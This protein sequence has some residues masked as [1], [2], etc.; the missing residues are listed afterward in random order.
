MR[1]PVRSPAVSGRFY[2][3]DPAILQRDVDRMLLEALAEEPEPSSGGAPA[4]RVNVPMAAIVPHAGYVFSGGVAAHAYARLRG[5][6]FDTVVLTGPDHYVG[7]GGVALYPRGAFATPLGPVEIDEDL[8][9]ALLSEGSPI[10]EMPEGHAREH[11][12]EVQLP[13]LK[14]VLP[15]ARIVPLL[16][17]HRSKQNVEALAAALVRHLPGRNALLL[18]STDL[19]HYHSRTEARVLDGRVV[20]LI[21]EM[22]SE[23]L[24]KLLAAG[25]GEAC[26]GDGLAAVLETCRRLGADRVEILRYADS[27]DV[28]GDTD[29]VVGYLAALVGRSAPV[30]AAKSAPAGA[31][32]A[33][34]PAAPG[35][36]PGAAGFDATDRRRLLDLARQSVLDAARGRGPADTETSPWPGH[37]L[38]PAGV[39]VTL[40]AGGQLRGCIGFVHP[41]LPLP[42]AVS[43]AA[44]SAARQDPRFSPVEEDEVEDLSVEISVLT[45]AVPGKPEDVVV[46]RHGLI[47]GDQG[48]RGLLLPQVATEQGWDRERF[49]IEVC[50]KAGLPRDAW[51]R[52]ARL[53]LF[54]AVVIR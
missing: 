32:T 49:L 4:D 35:N 14:R 37:L 44:W 36:A 48:R 18:A 5:G 2:P 26:G 45:P 43:Q 15:G 25:E 50:R 6:S 42:E 24:R 54:E 30:D 31:S 20:E 16:L 47:I 51:R 38:H 28:N 8:A 12:L 10:V 19:S 9:Q 40:K 3:S 29:G 1:E 41:T 7:F 33:D 17:G 27:G 22:D 11:S 13:F 34:A 21:R 52:G 23:G 53:E 39:F 46:G